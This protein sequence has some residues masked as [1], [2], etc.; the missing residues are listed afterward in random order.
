MNNK[1]LTSLV[2]GGTNGFGRFMSEGLKSQGFNVFTIGRSDCSDFQGD[3]SS[4]IGFEETLLQIKK[5]LHTIDLVSCVVGYAIAKEPSSQT[6]EDFEIAMQCNQGYVNQVLD[7]LSDNISD[8]N[9]KIIT[10]GSKWSL[11]KDCPLLL[12]YIEAKHALVD[13]VKFRSNEFI[14]SCYCVP[15]M[16]TPGYRGVLS[17]FKN[18]GIN[19]IPNQNLGDPK[20][21]AERIIYHNFKNFD[22]GGIYVVSPLGDITKN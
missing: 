10:I 15:S 18:I 3:I 8:V 5:E 11:R 13:L 9:G 14:T 17:S 12:P 7:I 6:K 21:I 20:N 4:Q 2:I 1:K 22:S 16:D 19:E